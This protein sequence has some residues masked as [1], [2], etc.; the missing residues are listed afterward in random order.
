MAP[1]IRRKVAARRAALFFFIAGALA[2][3]SSVV[4]PA[5][6]A[7]QRIFI[8]LGLLDI[9]LAVV[10]WLLPWSRWPR[11]ALLG[12]VPVGFVIIG[13]FYYVGATPLVVYPI[14]FILLFIWVGL[15]LPPWTSPA[16][17][18]LTAAA[19]ILPLRWPGPHMATIDLALV[20]V[21]L[22]ILIGE[23]IAQ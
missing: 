22:C 17:T 2:I 20:A 7:Q 21:P 19:Y 18:P 4:L 1:G 11:R 8:A 5:A 10:L 15:S 12:I 9:A 16:L 3:V 6:Q 23:V 14:F 13:L